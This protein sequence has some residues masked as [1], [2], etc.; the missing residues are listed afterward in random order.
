[1]LFNY[2]YF[3]VGL[4]LLRK[5]C[6]DRRSQSLAK[7]LGVQTGIGALNGMLR[8]FHNFNFNLSFECHRHCIFRLRHTPASAMGEGGAAVLASVH[9]SSCVPTSI[10]VRRTFKN[11]KDFRPNSSSRS[12]PRIFKFA[13][14][15]FRRS[16]PTA[17]LPRASGFYVILELRT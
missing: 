5:R 7:W 6:R 9:A 16:P 12:R 4:A 13:H 2:F 14:A 10:P 15:K 11:P 8:F 1:M 17:N 3:P